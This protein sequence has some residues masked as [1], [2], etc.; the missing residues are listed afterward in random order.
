M[1]EVSEMGEF[2][3]LH[4]LPAAKLRTRPDKNPKALG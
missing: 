2:F 1:K 4:E 3:G